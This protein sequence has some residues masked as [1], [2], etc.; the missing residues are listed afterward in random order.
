M[1]DRVIDPGTAVR[2]AALRDGDW[3]IRQPSLIGFLKS[4]RDTMGGDNGAAPPATHDSI[5]A[6]RL[7]ASSLP[8]C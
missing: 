2:P 8:F 1:Y 6:V 7:T 3:R 4:L 5:A